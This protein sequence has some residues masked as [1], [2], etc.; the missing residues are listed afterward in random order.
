MK[1]QGKLKGDFILIVVIVLIGL[2]VLVYNQIA[3]P[4]S[5]PGTSVVVEIEGEVV[6]EFKLSA[7]LAPQR[8]ETTHGYNV[9]E[10]DGGQ[11]RVVDAD[12]PDRLCVHTGWR[13]HAGQV[14][15]CLPHYFVV[16]IV[17]DSD[18]HGNLDGFT[19]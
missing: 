10:I 8:I 1:P 11:V 3:A 9:L 7:D 13:Q 19:Y 18:D 2:G 5:G 16:K 14:I 4:K 12:C 15:V 17:G 6:S